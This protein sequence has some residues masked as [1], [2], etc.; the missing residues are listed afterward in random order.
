MSNTDGSGSEDTGGPLT[1]VM[2]A[3]GGIGRRVVQHLLTERLRVRAHSRDRTGLSFGDGVEVVAADLI[4]RASLD[5]A[6]AG[7][8]Q[9]FLFAVPEGASALLA[10]ARA[11]GVERLVLL[12]SGSVLLPSSATNPITVGH[13]EVEQILNT[14]DGP[15]LV[16]IRPLVLATNAL[17][18]A[19]SIKAS[20]AVRLYQPD[21]L[22]A[23]VHE[24]DVAAVAAVALSTPHPA[25]LGAVSQLS[26]GPTR[27]SQR[28][29]VATLAQA[30]GRE[31]TVIEEDRDEALTRLSRFVPRPEAE[32]ILMFFDDCAAGNSPA[33]ETA[34]RVLGRDPDDFSTWASDHADDFR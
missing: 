7:V 32:A 22:S 25:D 2:G 19:H 23:P 29:Q 10:S 26:T 6:F 8:Q 4:D 1:L 9:A 18:W 3:R 5:A 28:A 30:L 15:A 13:R 17:G 27:L 33:T 16:P 11:A 20:G 34:R 14:S 31:L 21:A 24:A 12:S